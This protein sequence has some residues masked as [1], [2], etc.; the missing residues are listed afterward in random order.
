MAGLS[1]HP[2]YSIPSTIPSQ[3]V[4]TPTRPMSGSGITGD[5]MSCNCENQEGFMS[6]VP[7]IASPTICESGHEVLGQSISE[8]MRQNI[9][10]LPTMSESVHDVLGNNISQ[11]MRQKI[12]RGEYVDLAHLITKTNSGK[13]ALVLND[14]GEIVTREKLTHSVLTI[15]SWTDAFLVYISIYLRGHPERVQEMLK[16]MHTIRLAASRGYG[17]SSY[18]E[19][20]RLKRS[21]DPSSSWSSVD[22]ELWLIHMA[23]GKSVTKPSIKLT[24]KCFDF[25]YKG[26]CSKTSCQY[27]HNCMSCAGNHPVVACNVQNTQNTSRRFFEGSVQQRPIGFPRNSYRWGNPLNNSVNQSRPFLQGGNNRYSN[28]MYDNVG[29]R[30]G[31]IQRFGKRSFD[32]QNASFRGRGQQYRN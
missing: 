5:I 32:N 25:N 20:F 21:L 9:E 7:N 2:Q 17:W 4:G 28:S 22:F 12:A 23:D 29:P 24:G 6:S 13:T 10:C 30:Q 18:D 11:S 31:N 19:Q 15:D 26:Y 8:S 16:Y 3:F 1:Q 14:E 27:W